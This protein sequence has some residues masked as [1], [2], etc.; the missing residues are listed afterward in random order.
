VDHVRQWAKDGVVLI[1]DSAHAMSPLGGVGI[2]YAIHDAVAA[3]NILIPAFRS[4][5]LSLHVLRRIQARREKPTRRMQKFQVFMQD[6]VLSPLLREEGELQ[7]P[8]FLNM[9]RLFPVLRRI[10]ARII[11]MGFQPEHVR[12]EF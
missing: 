2:N 11:G 1:G 7:M 4:K 8:W 3:A 12:I 5:N 10:P 9:F 6:H